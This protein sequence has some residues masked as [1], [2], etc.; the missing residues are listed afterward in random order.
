VTTVVTIGNFDGVHRGHHAL[1]DRAR[2]TA[3]LRGASTVAVTFDP[4]PAAVLRPDAVPPALQSLEERVAMLEQ[5]GCDEVIV[6]TFDAQLAARTPEQFVVDLLVERLA[7][8]AVVVG[9]N[10]RFGNGA[11]GDVALLGRLGAAY[12]FTVEAVGLV[13]AGDGP[14]SSSAL[15]AL[16]AA[17]EVAAVARGLGRE[18]TLTGEV[19]AGD[20]RGR[21]LG[22]PTA[23][24]ALAPGRAVPADGVY[25]CWARVPDGERTPAVVNV[26]WRPTFEGRTRT[27]E[28]HLL[29]DP[30][31]G[32][33]D[34]EFGGP[35][36]YGRPLSLAFVARIRGEQR[37]D[38]P[39]ALVARI[40]QDIAVA[41]EL[42]GRG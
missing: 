8:V 31:P 38:G 20:G 4:H 9:E 22:I 35:D 7:A 11:I 13:D 19:V 30:S 25:A 15:R 27:V 37:F 28:A 3:Q 2:A 16:L 36:L 6:L 29:L 39:E 24:V 18:F 41:R 26:G 10:F 34:G 33:G 42:L 5:A 23:N 12:G 1:I 32:G 21:T 40:R 17:G 14:I